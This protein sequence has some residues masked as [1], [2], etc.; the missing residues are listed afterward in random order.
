V[1]WRQPFNNFEALASGWGTSLAGQC[2]TLAIGGVA[3]V[4]DG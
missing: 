4:T 2:P 3:T 1:L